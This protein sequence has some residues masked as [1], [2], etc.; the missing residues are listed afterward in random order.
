MRKRRGDPDLLARELPKT[1]LDFDKIPDDPF[2]KRLL[3][4]MKL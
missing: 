1:V 2:Q 4:Y 3:A